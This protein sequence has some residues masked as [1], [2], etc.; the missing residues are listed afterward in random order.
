MEQKMALTSFLL[1]FMG[2]MVASNIYTFIPIY[3]DIGQSLK[4]PMEKVVIA[5]SSFS[6]FYACGLL[7]FANI[8][9]RVGRKEVLVYGLAASAVCTVLVAVAFNFEWL[10]LSRGV[11]G[12][13][14]GSFAPVAFAYTY[15]LFSGKK[16]TFL[17]ALIN[18]GFLLAGIF[19]Q[20]ASDFITRWSSWQIVF[21]SFAAMYFIL[22]LLG[23]H[24]LPKSKVLKSREDKSFSRLVRLIFRKDLLYCYCIVFTLLASFVAYYDSLTRYLTLDASLLFT[25]RTV[26]LIGVLL[27]LFT[28][29]LIE[30]IGA[31][32]TL[33]LGIALALI[34][35]GILF[36]LT[37]GMNAPLLIISSVLFVSSISLLLPTI[38]T[39][40]G[41][42]SMEFRGQ[43]L[44]LYSFILLTGA[45]LAPLLIMHFSFFQ[46]IV[47]LLSFFTVDLFLAIGLI[48]TIKGTNR[49]E[50]TLFD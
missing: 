41:Q 8:A 37:Q 36:G 17:L 11:Q 29:R 30:K 47:L 46:S 33:F 43:A 16:R 20:L 40:I 26:G 6:F 19:G 18:S 32:G 4:L 25:I 42:L 44:S 21:V 2:I 5:S 13:F 34:S 38:I 48:R 28:G 27:S 45:S 23:R 10:L 35:I 31:F 7:V 1:V 49:K 39:F 24:S 3:E 22:F 15:D 14:L 9:E 50:S 12:F